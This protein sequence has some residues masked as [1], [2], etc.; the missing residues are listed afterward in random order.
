MSDMTRLAHLAANP[1][2][3][4]REEIYLAVTSLYRVQ[5]PWLS[6]RERA[7][8]NDILRRLAKDVRVTIRAS[9]AVRLANDE[10]VPPELVLLLAADVIEVARP[11]LLESPHLSDGDLIGLLDSTGAAHHEA[12]ASRAGI[13]E[14]LSERLASCKDDSILRALLRNRTARISAKTFSILAE[15]SRSSQAIC[16]QMLGRRDLPAATAMKMG[17]W[18]SPD[19]RAQLASR[20]GVTTANL[21]APGTKMDSAIVS[22][23]PN[24]SASE[25]ADKLVAKLA[26]SGQLRTGFLLRVLQQGQLDLFDAGLARMLD[27]PLEKSRSQFYAGGPDAVA[28]ACRA[29]GIDRC[30]FPTVYTLS[31]RSRGMMWELSQEERQSVEIVFASHSRPVALALLHAA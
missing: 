17:E 20:L 23:F 5:G 18:I 25:A 21:N 11:L 28:L 13:G 1:R 4:T 3:A 10:A 30:V 15:R 9:L 19:L 8:M 27:L 2:G 31:R 22:P 14:A 6:S 24:D 7:L 26:S 29:V 16:E 12:I